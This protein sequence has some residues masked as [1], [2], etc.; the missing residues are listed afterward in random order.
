MRPLS[1]FLAATMLLV[2]VY[3]VGR[4]LLSFGSRRTTQRD[5]DLVHVVMGVSMAG[6]LA[7]SLAAGPT[8][9]WLLVFSGSTAWFGW[10]VLRAADREGVGAHAQGQHVPHLLMSGAMVYMLVVAAWSGSLVAGHTLRMGAMRMNMAG[11]ARWPLLTVALAVLLLGDGVF[12]FGRSLR[13]AAVRAVPA[14]V[15]S[16]GVGRSSMAFEGGQTLTQQ[17]LSPRAVTQRSEAEASPLLAP[18]AAMVCQLVMS[19]VMGYMLVS[20]L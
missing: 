13:Q 5:A 9:L 15:A 18:R 4:L 16:E 10:R 19:L 20:L 14:A 3:C 11:A 2:A 6:M 1:D 12:T 17:T 7:P 8:D